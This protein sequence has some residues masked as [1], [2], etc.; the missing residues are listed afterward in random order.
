[1]IF[2]AQFLVFYLQQVPQKGLMV[3]R[4]PC[5]GAPHSLQLPSPGSFEEPVEVP[6]WSILSLTR[7]ACQVPSAADWEVPDPPDTPHKRLTLSAEVVS[8][9]EALSSSTALGAGPLSVLVQL[10]PLAQAGS[11]I[12]RPQV[13]SRGSK[14]P[15]M[16][17][18]KTAAASMHLHS[19]VCHWTLEGCP[20]GAPRPLCSAAGSATAMAPM[21][22]NEPTCHS[23]RALCGPT[24][25]RGCGPT[26]CA[27][28]PGHSWEQCRCHPVL[29]GARRLQP[30]PTCPGWGRLQRWV[31]AVLGALHQPRALPRMCKSGAHQ[32]GSEHPVGG[33]G[34]R[35]KVIYIMFLPAEPLMAGAFVL[36]WLAGCDGQ[37]A[38]DSLCST[39]LFSNLDP[40]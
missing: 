6:A 28:P 9:S 29:L 30:W 12:S 4:C 27:H 8:V 13:S 23:P 20:L 2:R 15:Q 39:A 33:K 36:Q 21:Q 16:H 31:P 40:S 5:W 35:N 19:F 1:M 25:G 17:A 7:P 24:C 3:L 34:Q 37:E 38:A 14:Q 11:A 18:A 26:P 10:H 22:C 32:P